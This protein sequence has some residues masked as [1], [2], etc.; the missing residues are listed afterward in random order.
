MKKLQAVGAGLALVF[1]LTACPGKVSGTAP[2]AP[3]G[4]TTTPELSAVSVAWQDDSDNE[5][6]FVIFRA[7]R[8]GDFVQLAEVGPN[9]TSYRDGAV[10]ADVVYRYA[11]AAKGAQN[12]AQTAQTGAGVSLSYHGEAVRT[13]RGKVAAYSAGEAPLVARDTSGAVGIPLGKGNLSAQGDF[14]FMYAAFTD[15]SPLPLCDPSEAGVEAAVNAVLV[16]GGLSEPVGGI[17]LA[18]SQAAAERVL[19]EGG[20]EVSD[21]V[22]YWWYV[23]EDASY[24]T[25]EDCL[26]GLEYDLELK[27]GWNTVVVETTGVTPPAARVV[28]AV[29]PA[30]LNWYFATFPEAPPP[31]PPPPSPPPGNFDPTSLVGF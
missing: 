22:T 17:V 4:V 21:V 15:V 31:P 30:N 13:F 20:G 11:V 1:L 24:Q 2:N 3:S 14:G 5:Q 8:E 9:V 23:A 25:K 12:S 16:V 26:F 7:V 18:S 28:T 10:E 6:G 29:P 27:A 19:S